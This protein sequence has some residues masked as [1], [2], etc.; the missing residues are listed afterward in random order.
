MPWSASSCWNI[1][2]RRGPCCFF[3]GNV[4]EVDTFPR[5]DFLRPPRPLVAAVS[6]SATFR[7][8]TTLEVLWCEGISGRWRLSG[9]TFS[10][11]RVLERVVRHCSDTRSSSV[12]SIDGLRLGSNSDSKMAIVSLRV[13]GGIFI[14][15][16]SACN[17]AFR[18]R[19][20]QEQERMSTFCGIKNN[21]FS[22]S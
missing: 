13:R 22:L 9:R 19:A 17:G 10:V 18:K 20:S 2:E 6:T 12:A 4:D 15:A 7:S 11:E 21:G 5:A 8:I 3:E 16:Q 1:A 14:S